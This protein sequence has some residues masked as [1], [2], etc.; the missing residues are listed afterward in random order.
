MCHYEQILWNCG[1]WRWDRF[2]QQCPGENRIGETCGLRLI[3][4]TILKHSECRLCLDI[5]KKDRRLVKM[6]ADMNRWRREA[7]KPATVE[8]TMFEYVQVYNERAAMAQQH[9]RVVKMDPRGLQQR[10]CGAA[11]SA[12]YYGEPL[13]SMRSAPMGYA[14]GYGMATP[15]PSPRTSP[16]PSGSP[17][18]N[19]YKLGVQTPAQLGIPGG[20]IAQVTAMQAQHQA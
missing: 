11:A 6:A 13:P 1:Y 17:A 3:Y 14:G 8:K 9:E 5:A 2:K 4:E 20:V 16:S 12:N 10:A 19:E 15:G 18:G 7:N